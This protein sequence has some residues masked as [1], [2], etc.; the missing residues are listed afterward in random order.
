MFRRSVAKPM[1]SSSL[2]AQSSFPRFAPCEDAVKMGGALLEEEPSQRAFLRGESDMRR[3]V[4]L[5]IG[6]GFLLTAPAWALITA[7][8][9][10]TGVLNENQ[11][12]CMAVVERVDPA[13]QETGRQPHRRR[14]LAEEE[15]DA[16]APQTRGAEA[17]A[18]PLRSP[19]R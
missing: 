19:K 2:S 4:I 11:F 9:P 13:V 17:A 10:L 15:R 16:I 18:D 12:I 7:L 1:K 14:R 6:L 8:T 5:S 3:I